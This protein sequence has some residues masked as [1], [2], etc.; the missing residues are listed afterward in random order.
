[1]RIEGDGR[2]R[3]EMEGEAKGRTEGAKWE[4]VVGEERE[5]ARG[6]VEGKKK[7]SGRE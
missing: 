5:R 4:S 7:D 2:E 1:M 3:E 6:A